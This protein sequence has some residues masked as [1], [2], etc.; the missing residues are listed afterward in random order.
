MSETQAFERSPTFILSPSSRFSHCSAAVSCVIWNIK[1]SVSRNPR[2]AGSDWPSLC[3][4]SRRS[5][6]TYREE[7]AYPCCEISMTMRSPATH[8]SRSVIRRK[9]KFQPT[10]ISVDTIGVWHLSRFNR[11][12]FSSFPF[13][14]PPLS[15]LYYRRHHPL[16]T[17][18]DKQAS[19]LPR[20]ILSGEWIAKMD[21]FPLFSSAFL[22][23]RF[24]DSS[25]IR[26]IFRSF[27]ASLS[28]FWDLAA[29]LSSMND[30]VPFPEDGIHRNNDSWWYMV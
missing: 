13:P 28:W 27:S 8:Y 16:S 18:L 22:R 20:L 3:R 14:F 25:G 10:K 7:E 5:F 21:R 19:L 15:S 17:L 26:A 12:R 11:P 30:G 9:T 29:T 2:A 24:V 6:P 1:I 4:P 23:F